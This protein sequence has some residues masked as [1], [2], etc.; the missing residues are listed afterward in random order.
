MPLQPSRPPS[1]D[2]WVAI[3]SGLSVGEPAVDAPRTLLFIDWIKGMLGDISLCSK[4][5][6]LIICGA[7]PRPSS[8]NLA[9]ALLPR[10]LQRCYA[11]LDAAHM[12]STMYHSV[13]FPERHVARVAAG[14]THGA[15]DALATAQPASKQQRFAMEA[16][17]EVDRCATELASALPVDLM[18]GP[19]DLANH[20]LPQQ[21]L[22]RC[23]FP[24]AA[25]YASFRRVTNPYRCKLD[26]VSLLGTSGQNI[27]DVQ[28]CAYC[29]CVQSS[30]LKSVCKLC[31]L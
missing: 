18:P 13:M 1:G 15:T 14:G 31:A 27:A 21:P 5:C 6:R 2:K 28:R 19:G 10:Q 22:H 3:A 16:V 7:L 8:A 11:S 30:R 20:A 25:P 12:H 24:G 23:L 26:G 9:T 4:V 17:R 29:L